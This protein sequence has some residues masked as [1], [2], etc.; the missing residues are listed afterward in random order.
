MNRLTRTVVYHL[1][2][3]DSQSVLAATIVVTLVIGAFH[4][5][6]LD[7]QNLL[8]ILQESVYIGILAAGMSFLLALLAS[9]ATKVSIFAIA[10]ATTFSLFVGVGFGLWPARQAAQ[11][12]PIEALRYE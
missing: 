5:D 1:R 7:L 4:H 9:W 3:G 8:S 12:N 11:L 6:F 2:T 10:L